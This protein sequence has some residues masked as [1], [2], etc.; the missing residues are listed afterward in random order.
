MNLKVR[1]ACRHSAMKIRFDVL[2]SIRAFLRLLYPSQDRRVQLFLSHGG[3][4]EGETEMKFLI[5]LVIGLLIVPI[6][7]WLYLTAGSPPVATADAPLPFEARLSS[8]FRCT[9]ALIVS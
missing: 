7:I 5:G 2:V 1:T 9:L 8:T 3:Q 6:G 4:K